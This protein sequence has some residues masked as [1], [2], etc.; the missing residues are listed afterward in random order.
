MWVRIYNL[1]LLA[2]GLRGG[3]SLTWLHD[4]ITNN[5]LD[6]QSFG[7]LFSSHYFFS[8][9]G[10]SFATR[11]PRF[12]A[13]RD[14]AFRCSKKWPKKVNLK[15]AFTRVHYARVHRF[16][17][18]AFTSSPIVLYA[19]WI[20]KLRVKTP[21]NFAFTFPSPI[22]FGNDLREKGEQ[23]RWRNIAFFRF[24]KTLIFSKLHFLKKCHLHPS[25]RR[26]SL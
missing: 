8:S 26:I 20:S 13:A 16:S 25:D 24:Q 21:P 1:S 5:P 17:F 9:W 14:R 10:R 23:M 6:T 22:F 15:S 19:L 2:S 7:L 12:W 18:F 3:G 11:L 4:K